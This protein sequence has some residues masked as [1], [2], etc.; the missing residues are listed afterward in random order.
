MRSHHHHHHLHYSPC[1][2]ELLT[3]CSRS[4]S[5]LKERSCTWSSV[6]VEERPPPPA[7]STSTSERICGWHARG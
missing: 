5:V 7:I 2:K 3:A 1:G 4:L 6:G